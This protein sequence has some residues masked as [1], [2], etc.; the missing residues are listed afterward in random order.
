MARPMCGLSAGMEALVFDRAGNFGTFSVA[1]VDAA[2]AHLRHLGG[3]A[4]YAFQEGAYVTEASSHTYYFDATN[5]LLRHYD[6]DSTDTPVIDDVVGV[7][8]EY[9]GDAHPPR[10][11]KPPAGTPNCLYDDEGNAR[12]GLVDMPVTGN[13]LVALPLAMFSDGPWCG[14]G[15]DEFDA[16]LL[17]VRKIRVT[18][19]VQ[20][21]QAS[22][23]GL[24]RAFVV[25]GTSTSALRSLPDYTLTF[26]VSPRNMSP[27]R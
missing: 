20:A 11:P 10:S 23:R 15:D 6:D 25:P 24:G 13:S 17:R 2:A 5:H 19:R 21:A 7:R 22:L 1:S 9:F 12:E 8:F 26:D 18:I 3:S 4:S 14:A 27:G 16:D